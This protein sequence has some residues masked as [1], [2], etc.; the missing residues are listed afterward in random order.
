[1][2][3]GI[4]FHCSKGP[5]VPNYF[6]GNL[7]F[8]FSNG[9][10]VILRLYNSRPTHI[11]RQVSNNKPIYATKRASG[12]LINGRKLSEIPL[13]MN[14]SGREIRNIIVYSKK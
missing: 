13:M 1:M 10:N 3:F 7:T 5:D 9:Q 14:I 11:S 4:C 12:Y 6:T 2:Q 8:F